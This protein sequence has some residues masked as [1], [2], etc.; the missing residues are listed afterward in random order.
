MRKIIIIIVII[1][2]IITMGLGIYFYFHYQKKYDQEIENSKT[3]FNI[4]ELFYYSSADAIQNMPES[5]QLWNLNLYQYTNIA[6]K[7]N[8]QNEYTGIKSKNTIKEL[9]IDNI[10]IS[11]TPLTGTLALYYKNPTLLTTGSII[12]DNVIV[13]KLDYSILD[14]NVE[15]DY[16]IPQ[17][18]RDGGI[19]SL[20]I[21]NKDIYDNFIINNTDE[22]VMYD[23][24]LL[25]KAGIPLENLSYT[26]SFDIYIINDLGEK[27]KSTISLDC[28]LI[29]ETIPDNTIYSGFIS[30]YKTNVNKFTK[31]D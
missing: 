11:S 7:I 5:G 14:F 10:Q 17:L 30:S 21:L 2:L 20:Q 1:L 3:I 31:V 26:I 22:I 16:S 4:S 6:F 27:F 12:E 23:G 9:Y 18:N 28:P 29:D 25:S 8:N 13:D 15:L 24:T 19:I